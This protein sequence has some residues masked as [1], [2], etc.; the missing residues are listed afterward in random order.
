M[1]RAKCV[2]WCCGFISILAVAGWAATNN[3][4]NAPTFLR[5]DICTDAN[6]SEGASDLVIPGMDPEG[7]DVGVDIDAD[8]T[9]D[10]WLSQERLNYHGGGSYAD[11]ALS[12]SGWRT[13]LFPLDEHAGKQ[14]KIRIVDKSTSEYIAVNAIRLN[15]ADGVVVPNP[16]PNG[17]FEDATPLNGWTILEGA[18]TNA[19]DLI[20][21]GD[22]APYG[23]KFFHST[24][25]GTVVVES[26]AFALEPVTSFV[27]GQ[28]NGSGSE[29]WNHIGAESYVY[30]DIGTEAENPNGQYDAGVDVP[31]VG[32]NAEA[33]NGDAREYLFSCFMNTSG[34]EGKRAQIV[35]VDNSVDDSITM[36]GWRM[37]WDLDVIRN[38]DFGEGFEG[39][40]LPEGWEDD[41][42]HLPSQHPSG[43]IPGWTVT[44]FGDVQ[45]ADFAYFSGSID[46]SHRSGRTY[47]GSGTWFE[48][49]PATGE[50]WDAQGAVEG[51]GV[52]LRSDVFVIQP[53]PDPSQHVF[54]QFASAQG[55]AKF[56]GPENR[57][58]VALIIDVNG[59]GQFGELGDDPDDYVYFMR[60]Q[61]MGWAMTVAKMDMWHYPEYRFYILPE[62]YGKQAQIYV[63]DSLTGSYGWLCV[64]DFFLWTGQEAVQPFENA[65][66]EMGISAD[67]TIPNWTDDYW[68]GELEQAGWLGASPELVNEN[69][70]TLFNV[71]M[72]GRV[73]S[74]DGDYCGDSAGGDGSTGSLTSVAFTLPTLVSRV[75][76]WSIF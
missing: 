73:G 23:T 68:S 7:I 35:A 6:G 66:F 39:G 47:V 75:S 15:N 14:V 32:H 46:S 19:A 42:P 43:G 33:R 30:L 16:V 4:A 37:N 48:V 9:V 24:G 26:D 51:V 18:T 76:E 57:G 61:G 67:F 55:S 13:Y 59:N 64:D 58:Y 1:R 53:I 60:A 70:D 72:N 40:E 45:D 52:E 62:H 27:R 20:D 25:S 8:G 71:A 3:T 12:P 49:D 50:I 34:L 54:F 5:L 31:L 22:A 2:L 56:D 65:D 36:A 29:L 44:K 63:E 10:R 17:E 69:P 38:G 11:D 21:T 41:G 74:L 28:V